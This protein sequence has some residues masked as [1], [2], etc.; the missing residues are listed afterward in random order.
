[1]D[2]TEPPFVDGTITCGR[3]RGFRVRVQDDIANTGGFLI[4]TRHLD[5]GYDNWV[6]SYRDLAPFFK[7]SGWAVKWDEPLTKLA[8]PSA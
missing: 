2:T 6:E 5:E 7:E 8:R 3:L 4:L 1:M